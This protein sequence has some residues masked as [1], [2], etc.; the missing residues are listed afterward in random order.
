MVLQKVVKDNTVGSIDYSATSRLE[1]HFK[2]LFLIADVQQDHIA[3]VGTIRADT[4]MQEEKAEEILLVVEADALVDPNAV[5][6]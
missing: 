2:Q 1:C 6:V 3:A 4:G 5:M